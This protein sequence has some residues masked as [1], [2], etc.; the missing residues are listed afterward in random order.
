[1]WKE[2]ADMVMAALVNTTQWTQ[3]EL[4]WAC[5]TCTEQRLPGLQHHMEHIY[6]LCMHLHA[7]ICLTSVWLL[8]F[9][10]SDKTRKSLISPRNGEISM[11][12][13]S[14][15]PRELQ[16]VTTL[17]NSSTSYLAKHHFYHPTVCTSLRFN[18]ECVFSVER[19][20]G[21]CDLEG[22]SHTQLS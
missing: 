18:C 20:K 11:S 10:F 14:Q 9:D 19:A 6:D 15:E 7:L 5:A 21:V 17:T 22:L 1:M 16:F 4:R 2:P 12:K 13:R 8:C 3:R